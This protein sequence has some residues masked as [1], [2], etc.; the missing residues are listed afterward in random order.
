MTNEKRDEFLRDLYQ[1]QVEQGHS[2]GGQITRN[3]MTPEEY[4]EKQAIIDYWKGKGIVSVEAAATGFV[5]AKLTSFGI[6]HVERQ[7]L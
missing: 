7:L 1:F 5:L 3:S 4:R 6:D 2:K